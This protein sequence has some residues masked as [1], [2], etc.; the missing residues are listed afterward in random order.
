MTG[1]TLYLSAGR[2][3]SLLVLDNKTEDRAKFHTENN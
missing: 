3:D 1:F 2:N